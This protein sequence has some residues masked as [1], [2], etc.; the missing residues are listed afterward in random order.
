MLAQLEGMGKDKGGRQSQVNKIVNYAQVTHGKDRVGTNTLDDTQGATENRNPQK[1]SMSDIL[2][3]IKG[4]RSELVTK[5]DP[6]AVDFTLLQADLCKLADRFTEAEDTIVVLNQ[7][8]DA[9][10]DTVSS[11]QKLTL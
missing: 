5:I 11:L 10:K 2:D 6:V 3:E 9:L 7:E 1:P 4:T 8:V